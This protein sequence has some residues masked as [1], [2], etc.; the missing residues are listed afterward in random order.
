MSR[1]WRLLR[2]MPAPLLRL[3]RQVI[4]A[5]RR[6]RWRERFGAKV[7][8]IPDGEVTVADG[9]RFHIG[10]DS[11]YWAIHQGLEYEP[12]VTALWR[13]LTRA[14][15]V[16]VDAGANFGWFTTLFATLAGRD[17]LVLAFEPVPAT[18][19]RLEEH[20]TL[21]PG[22]ARVV[23]R[24]AALAE[25]AGTGSVTIPAGA[26]GEASLT[27]G[28]TPGGLAVPLV[29]L[30]D[31]LAAI[32]LD[33]CD[34]L[35]LDVEGAELRALRGARRTLRG[36]RPP[37][38]L[39]ELN[40]AACRSAGYEPA[41]LYDF[42]HEAGYDAFFGIASGRRLVRVSGPQEFGSLAAGPAVPARRDVVPGM[43]VAAP[44]TRIV[45]RLEDASIVIREPATG[46][47]R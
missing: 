18:F 8:D 43:A 29:R 23:L 40:A 31:E 20:V 32:G 37:I 10:P 16:A 13:S 14:G 7:A 1:V 12:E 26:S 9:R 24:A 5:D 17:G 6:Y 42:L 44:R 35:K 33:G 4:P 34:L 36:P 47:A 46:R 39:V 25:C 38:I 45:P 30:D 15:D 27:S 22:P 41:A 2:W 3:A 21:N 19:A 28:A 11:M